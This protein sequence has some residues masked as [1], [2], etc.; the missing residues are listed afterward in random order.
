[1]PI[2]DDCLESPASIGYKKRIFRRLILWRCQLIQGWIQ[3]FYLGAFW[4][5]WI[6]YKTHS[7]SR[8][9]FFLGGGPSGPATELHCLPAFLYCGRSFS[10]KQ[11]R[12][13]SQWNDPLWVPIRTQGRLVAEPFPSVAM[14]VYSAKVKESRLLFVFNQKTALCLKKKNLMF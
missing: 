9:F 2:E 8:F 14:V 4:Y 1:M 7:Q 6:S 12:V 3:D 11:A 13:S 5:K 10:M